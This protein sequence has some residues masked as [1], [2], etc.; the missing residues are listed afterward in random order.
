MSR[1]H[2]W[3]PRLVLFN[4]NDPIT[5]QPVIGPGVLY[6]GSQGGKIYAF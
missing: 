2:H 1:E 3:Q 4:I 5:T 6:V